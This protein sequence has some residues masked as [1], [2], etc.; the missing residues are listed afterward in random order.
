[1]FIEGDTSEPA[2]RRL[3]ADE[4]EEAAACLLTLCKALFSYRS[5]HNHGTRPAR[6][7]PFGPAAPPH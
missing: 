3:G 4:A 5:R 2:G 1:M 6:A 7:G